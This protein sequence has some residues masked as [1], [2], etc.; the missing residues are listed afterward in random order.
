MTPVPSADAP[1]RGRCA[2]GAVSFEVTE[3]FTTAGYFH[4]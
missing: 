1:L 2:C 4:C 3:P